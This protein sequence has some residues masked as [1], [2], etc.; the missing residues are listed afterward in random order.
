LAGYVEPERSDIP[1]QLVRTN[2]GV[3]TNVFSIGLTSQL[4][5]QRR[6]EFPIEVLVAVRE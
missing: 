4:A 1:T 6:I 5:H 2:P 3:L